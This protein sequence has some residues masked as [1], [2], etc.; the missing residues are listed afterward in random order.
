MASHLFEQVPALVAGEGLDQMLLGGGQHPAEPDHNQIAD[1]MGA[2]VLWAPAHVFLLES[3]HA[4]G[5]FAF[6]FALCFHGSLII[7]SYIW[8]VT[9]KHSQDE[10]SSPARSTIV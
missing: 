6:D 10:S 5:N 1:Q 8:L 4:L 3:A 7:R 2:N 9:R